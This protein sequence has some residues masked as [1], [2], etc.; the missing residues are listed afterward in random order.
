M[1]RSSCK[2]LIINEK[3][4]FY[5]IATLLPSQCQHETIIKVIFSNIEKK[6]KSKYF[7]LMTHH[8]S[9]LHVLKV[10]RAKKVVQRVDFSEKKKRN[11]YIVCL[12]AR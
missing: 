3:N 9:I 12:K 6:R 2:R 8:S 10:S 1:T 11:Y 5:S 7:V 4:V